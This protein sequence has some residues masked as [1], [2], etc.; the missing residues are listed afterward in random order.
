M[1]RVFAIIVKS[2]IVPVRD[3]EDAP[4]IIAESRHLSLRCERRHCHSNE[5]KSYHDYVSEFS[6]GYSGVWSTRREE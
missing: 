1:I 4:S 6:R 5:K 2:E 3:H